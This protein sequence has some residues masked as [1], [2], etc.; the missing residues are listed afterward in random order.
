MPS[1]LYLFPL[2]NVTDESGQ[3]E[4]TQQTEDLCEAH[5]AEG[6]RSA[7]HVSRVVK[8]LQ[9]N[10]QENVINGNGGDEVYREPAAK[11]MHA[12]FLGVQDDVAVLPQ[13]ASAEVESQI[14]E[15]ERV[16]QDIEGD[17]G[18]GVLVLEEGYAPG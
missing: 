15:E 2:V 11:V 8:G 14:H 3:S 4:K 16:G 1:L 10:D 9:V 17:P 7:V 12:D 13:D 6:T 5:N 18:C